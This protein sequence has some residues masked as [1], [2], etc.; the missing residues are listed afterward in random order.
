MPQ[1]TSVVLENLITHSETSHVGR[2]ILCYAVDENTNSVATNQADT[3]IAGLFSLQ[4][5]KSWFV[6]RFV[7][8]VRIAAVKISN[9]DYGNRKLKLRTL[10]LKYFA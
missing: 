5:Y 8:A 6:L 7:V 2:T 10:T 1:V 4:K 3:Q 9:V